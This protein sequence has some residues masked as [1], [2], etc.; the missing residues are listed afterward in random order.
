LLVI[1]DSINGWRRYR[2]VTRADKSADAD[3]LSLVTSAAFDVA[4]GDPLRIASLGMAIA[5][6]G[7]QFYKIA[8][9]IAKENR[10]T[11][12][13]VGRRP[14]DGTFKDIDVLFLEQGEYFADRATPAKANIGRP[15][16]WPFGN[17]IN[18]VAKL[19]NAQNGT[20][21]CKL[22]YEYIAFYGML[23]NDF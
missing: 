14:R 17:Q 7:H 2:R 5:I 1:S 20:A 22:A 18:T 10:L 8:V 9:D 15:Y 19:M 16:S 4:V 3:T 12:P 6:C 11:R 23:S 21:D 13:S